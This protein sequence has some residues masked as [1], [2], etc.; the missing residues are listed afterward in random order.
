M[1][2]TLLLSAC[3]LLVHPWSVASSQE[4]EPFHTRNLSPPIAIFGLP[5]WEAITAER[6]LTA[7]VEVANHFRLSQRD[8]DTLI[9]DG[10]TTRVDL[11][12]SRPLGQR[13]S[14]S[15]ELPLL[16]QTGGV[17]DDLIDG[18]HSAFR[19]P[20]GGRNN[21]S[22]DELLFQMVAQDQLFYQLDEDRRGFGDLQLGL[23]RRFGS[24]EGYVGRLVVKVP[25][26]RQSMLAGSG[27]TDWSVTVLRPR[28]VMLR[29][30]EAGYYW[31]V[32]Y[33]ALGEPKQ[34]AYPAKD[35]ALIG[36]LGGS[37]K[38]LPRF[39]LKV[40][41]DVFS[42]MYDT[43][44]EELGQNAVQATIGGWWE[45]G[46]RTRVEFGVNEDL[47]V[48]TAPDVVLHLNLRWTW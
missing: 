4:S 21:R 17:L 8:T 13:W 3:L 16:Q 15:A 40:Q 41:I 20:D 39:G 33:L 43:P 10:E 47:H 38:V 7:T 5:M 11:F 45:S 9:V 25:T 26:G 19:L 6:V 46:A 42:A 1:R 28:Q 22:E 18:W 32:G 37:L 31:G 23:A 34:I 2:A 30:R 36:I 44:L 35:D 24:G 27:S 14:I 12:Y 29:R 48:S